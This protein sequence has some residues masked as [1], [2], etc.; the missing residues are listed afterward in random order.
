MADSKKGNGKRRLRSFNIGNR[1]GH[2][3]SPSRGQ[4]EP[5]TGALVKLRIFAIS[6]WPAFVPAMGEN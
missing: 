2:C 5:L 6:A 4:T 3:G 1:H